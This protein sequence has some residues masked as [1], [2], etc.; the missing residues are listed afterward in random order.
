MGDYIL[1]LADFKSRA[2]FEDEIG[3]YA[4]PVDMHPSKPEAAAY[5]KFVQEY[6]TLRYNKGESYGIPYRIVPRNL[7]NV[8][9][10]G[11]C[12]DSDR[13]IQASIRVMPGCFI[14]G[15]AAGAAAALAIDKNT[16]TRGFPVAMLQKRLMDL[17]IIYP[18]STGGKEV[19]RDKGN[20]RVYLLAWGGWVIL[21]PCHGDF[22]R[23]ACR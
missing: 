20:R 16:H 12:V 10:A 17:A 6:G 7:S 9:V 3:R 1:N 23:A 22:T 8:L 14:T 11:R 5:K 4:Y 21:R 13:S 2:V 18:A 19:K 15:Q